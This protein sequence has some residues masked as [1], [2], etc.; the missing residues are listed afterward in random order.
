MTGANL[1]FARLNDA[2]L[3]GAKLVGADLTHTQFSGADLT[4]AD[5]TDTE[6]DTYFL[7]S[8]CFD[9]ETRWPKSFSPPSNPNGCKAESS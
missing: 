8:V 4:G 1:K 2:D 6:L 7:D 9:D 3:T 5:L